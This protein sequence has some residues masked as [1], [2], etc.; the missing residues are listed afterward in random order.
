MI[1]RTE[2]NSL[3]KGDKVILNCLPD[4]NEGI[5]ARFADQV[6][7]ISVIS[8]NLGMFMATLGSSNAEVFSYRDIETIVVPDIKQDFDMQ[9]IEEFLS[10]YT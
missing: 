8:Q 1:S 4:I 9:N 7:N 6:V 2:F 5:R 10:E 3:N